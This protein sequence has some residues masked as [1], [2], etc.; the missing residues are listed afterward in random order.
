MLFI[1]VTTFL[2]MQWSPAHIHLAEHHNHGGINHQHK[3]E[4]H[5]HQSITHSDN[6]NN[7]SHQI[8]K[9][10]V[11]VVEIDHEYNIKS[12]CYFDEQYIASALEYFY[13]SYI[14]LKNNLVATELNN[15]KLRYLDY[16][17]LY[18]RAPPK[19]S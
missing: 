11:N 3:I 15:S 5:V 1:L 17:T 12:G 18:G 13:L 6:Y 4:S 2:T 14:P 8:E 19:L 16:N 10:N 9:H 7:A